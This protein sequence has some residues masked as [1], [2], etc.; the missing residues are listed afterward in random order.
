MSW[1]NMERK[2]MSF[3]YL[4]LAAMDNSTGFHIIMGFRSNSV[5]LLQKSFTGLIWPTCE[6]CPQ[7]S[8][9]SGFLSVLSLIPAFLSHNSLHLLCDSPV[10]P[11]KQNS[12]AATKSKL[13]LPQSLLLPPY[14][15]LYFSPLPL[16]FTICFGTSAAVLTA[17]DFTDKESWGTSLPLSNLYSIYLPL[18]LYQTA[19][20]FIPG[21]M[22]DTMRETL[23]EIKFRIQ[24]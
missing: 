19:I 18:H 4:D 9:S 17:K 8:T 14:F 6:L 22:V 3:E 16:L 2:L 7:Y 1:E 15:P 20:L 10:Y 13:R 11:H 24:V 5:S 12:A 21:M 23:Y